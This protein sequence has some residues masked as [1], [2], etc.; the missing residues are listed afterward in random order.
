MKTTL[1]SLFFSLIFS[2]VNGQC[3]KNATNFGNNTS[4]N[5]YN[6]SG[7]VS[8]TLNSNNTVAINFGSNFSTASGPDVR[9]YL[10]K[11]E[12][13]S[14]SE[15]KS[16]NPENVQNISFGLIGFSG[17]QSFTKIIPNGVDI[18]EYDTVFFFCLQFTAFWDLGKITPFSSANCSVLS[19]ESTILNKVKIYPN[20]AKKE[21]QIGNIEANSAEIRIFNVLGK[22]VFYQQKNT[23]KTLDISFLQSGI[24]MVKVSVENASKTQKLVIQ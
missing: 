14:I 23:G 20:P 11:S 24:Y 2:Q 7:D 6:I 15:L 5:S 4:T 22:K 17:A 10:I 16:I 8:V 13:K 9:L 19:A 18:S 1:L 21:I 3:S 12:G